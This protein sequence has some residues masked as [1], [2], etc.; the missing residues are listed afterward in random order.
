MEGLGQLLVLGAAVLLGKHLPWPSS[1]QGGRMPCPHRGMM[2]LCPLAWTRRGSWAAGGVLAPGGG[3]SVPVPVPAAAQGQRAR[4]AHGIL[5]CMRLPLTSWG[6][7]GGFGVPLS[8]VHPR[9]FVGAWQSSEAARGLAEGWGPPAWG[10][11]VSSL[12][13]QA[14]TLPAL[15]LI[16]APL[17]LSPS[18]R[19]QRAREQHC[20]LPPPWR[21][22]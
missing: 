4:S 5:G 20:C 6:V 18:C 16:W 10:P 2:L 21:G 13:R 3:C 7:H 1:G 9:E 12:P 17:G 15:L 14:G 8:W 22:G 19:G 11:L